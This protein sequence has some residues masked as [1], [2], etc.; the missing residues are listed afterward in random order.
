MTQGLEVRGLSVTY[1]GAHPR[2]AVDDVSLSL[3]RGSSLALV[4]P[5]GSGKSSM[6]L[7][8]AGV[9][10]SSGTVSW[11][12]E[13]LTHVPTHQRNF[14]VV[15]QDGQLFSH[16]TVA[17]NVGYA[18][19]GETVQGVDRFFERTITEDIKVIWRWE[20]EFAVF[21]ESATDA[22]ATDNG[23][24]N[25]VPA[26]GRTWRGKNTQLSAAIDSGKDLSK[27]EI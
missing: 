24:G 25:P 17:R 20:L 11:D 15:F 7:A 23:L 21:I 14:G 27:Y 13:D 4:G 5:S 6:L 19:D 12:G 1:G 9:V 18:I 10:P 16:L 2:V 26:V 8:I 22:G 3:P